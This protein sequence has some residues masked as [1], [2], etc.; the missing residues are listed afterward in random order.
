M[1][2]SFL[3]SALCAPARSWSRKCTA[4]TPGYFSAADESID[5]T[6]ACGCGEVGCKNTGIG[7][8][9]TQIAAARMFHIIEARVLVALQQTGA[10]HDHSR[11]AEAALKR[12]VIDELFLNR[13]KLVAL[14]EPLDSL[15]L[16]ALR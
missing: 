1:N 2:F 13:M 8:A 11:R 4:F 7:A 16:L 14:G 3:S 9:A 5:F 6:F 15:D 10:A 12:V